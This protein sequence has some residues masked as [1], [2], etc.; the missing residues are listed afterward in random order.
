ME[1]L[2]SS[3]DD[4]LGDVQDRLVHGRGAKPLPP[5]P[6]R[7][8]IGSDHHAP[9]NPSDRPD[10]RTDSSMA[11]RDLA[12]CTNALLLPPLPPLSHEAGRV[13]INGVMP[14]RELD[15][16]QRHLQDRYLDTLQDQAETLL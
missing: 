12:R 15:P 3:F 9:R 10:S 1:K 13:V 6:L 14:E 16:L 5:K 11:L 8:P 2:T 4:E 7:Y